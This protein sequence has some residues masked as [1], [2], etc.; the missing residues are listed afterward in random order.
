MHWGVVGIVSKPGAGVARVCIAI[1]DI[2]P[3]SPALDVLPQTRMTGM[4]LGGASMEGEILDSR[5]NEQLGAV[6]HDAD[7]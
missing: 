2:R 4:G 3:G 7:G 1:T 5:S 6:I